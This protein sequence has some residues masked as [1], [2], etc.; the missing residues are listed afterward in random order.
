M[1]I[2]ILY[3][4]FVHEFLLFFFLRNHLISLISGS[5]NKKGYRLE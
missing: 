4:F 5:D 2:V 3:D 1:I